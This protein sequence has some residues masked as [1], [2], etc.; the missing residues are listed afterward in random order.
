M[1]Q[2]LASLACLQKSALAQFL[3]RLLK[4]IGVI[5]NLIVAITVSTT[6]TTKVNIILQSCAQNG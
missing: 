1:K 4:L 6:K 3:E 2:V 5:R